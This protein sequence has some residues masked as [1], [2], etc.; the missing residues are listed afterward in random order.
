ME[1]R[2]NDKGYRQSD[3]TPG[4]W[5]HDWRP[6]SFS[7]VVDG[8]GVKYVGEQHANHLLAVLRK[9]YVVNKN[10]K[11]NKYC[12]VTIDWDYDKG[13][14]HLSM[15]GYCLEALQR[16]RHDSAQRTNQPHEQSVPMNGA[17][18]QYAKKLD[19]SPDIGPADKLFIQQVTS[20][21][22]YYARA[23]NSTMLVTLSTIASQ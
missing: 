3:T 1:K 18:V 17:K 15:P 14:V 6:I 9:D 10:A 20:T 23:A 5:K 4:Y 21:F 8:F 19:K 7:L 16:F 2:L 13:K 11:G 12:G 22:L